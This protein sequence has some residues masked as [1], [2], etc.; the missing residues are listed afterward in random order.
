MKIPKHMR[1][2]F[3]DEAEA[4]LAEHGL[5]LASVVTGADAWTVAHRTGFAMRCY[6]MSR[7]IYDSHIQTVLKSV[8]PNAIFGGR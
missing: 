4:F 6:D 7:D 5:A 1:D 2:T 3:R 8:F